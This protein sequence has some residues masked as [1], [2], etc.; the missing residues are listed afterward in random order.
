MNVL[1]LRTV[2]FSY[3]ISNAV[4]A[5]GMGALWLYRR[6]LSPDLGFWLA[7]FIMQVLAL[8]LVALRGMVPDFFSIVVG[9]TLAVG[10]TLVLYIGLERYLGKRSSQRYNYMLLAVFIFV[11]TWFSFVQPSL[12]VRNINLSLGL[13]VFCSESAWLLL[14]RVDVELRAVT[15]AVGVIFGVYSLVSLARIFVDLIV[16]PGNDLMKMGLYDTLVLLIYQM[17]FIGLTL[18]LL[19]M[20]NRRLVAELERD[21]TKRKGIESKLRY[22]GT[23]DALTGLYNRSFFEEELARI[24]RRR[25]F[26]LS[27]LMADVDDLKVVNDSQGHAA[28]DNLLKR[29]A[30]VLGAAFRVEDTLARIGGDEFAVLLPDTTAAQ[31]EVVLDRVRCM[32]Q[33]NNT[34]RTAA[35]IQISLGISTAV[36]RTQLA[37][38]LKDADEKMYRDK[39]GPDGP[40]KDQVS[41]A[42]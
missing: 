7:D 11:Q 2:L 25:R 16:P 15:R 21:I 37:A 3:V 12:L 36:D 42:S 27:V 24:E 17:L 1:D 29:V 8:L 26:P 23:H 41:G 40:R 5:L 22:L 19:L 33:E 6:R 4:C 14:H 18:G 30:R 31:A 13:L 34:V 20:R 9:N 32:V 35:Q 28:G 38:V 10:G 39:R